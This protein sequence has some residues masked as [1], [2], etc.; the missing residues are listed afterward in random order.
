MLDGVAGV[1]PP[2]VARFR[3]FAAASA[4]WPAAVDAARFA[5]GGAGATSDTGP[6][7][8]TCVW[9]AFGVPLNGRGGA[10]DVNQAIYS[11][12]LLIQAVSTGT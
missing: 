4:A 6:G 8:L 3:C 7:A 2:D 9:P 12:N 11:S 10:G 5:S 1:L